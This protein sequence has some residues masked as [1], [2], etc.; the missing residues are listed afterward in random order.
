MP[1]LVSLLID[2]S[3]ERQMGIILWLGMFVIVLC[4]LLVFTVNRVGDVLNSEAA[5]VLAPSVAT[6][7]NVA[8]TA[9]LL[10]EK[11]T[12]EP[13]S[14]L[15][16]EQLR[17][18]A[19][20][21]DGLNEFVYAPGGVAQ[22]SVNLDFPP[23]SLGQPMYSV[24]GEQFYLRVS[25]DFLGLAGRSAAIS[26]V[27]DFGIVIPPSPVVLSTAPLLKQEVF[28]NLQ[29]GPMH[30]MGVEGLHAKYHSAIPVNGPRYSD[31]SVYH[32]RCDD[33]GLLCV[34]SA[35]SLISVL[36]VAWP[37]VALGLTVAALVAL[38]MSTQLHRLIRHY[39]SFESRFVRSFKSR[40]I[41]CT[42][43]PILSIETGQIFGCEV[44]VRWR[45]VDGST[46]FPDQFLPIVARRGLSRELTRMVVQRAFEELSAKVPPH[47]R[48]QVNINI[49][50]ADLDAAWLRHTLAVFETFEDRF[51]VVVE[52]VESTEIE[53]EHAA[54]E[55]EKLR[56]YGIRTQLDD[57]GTGYSNIQNLASLPLDGVK[58]DRSFAMAQD[59]ALMHRM[60]FSTIEMIHSAG[61]RLTVEGVESEARLRQLAATGH[62]QYAQGYHIARPVQIDRFVQILGER[63]AASRPR[64]VA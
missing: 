48:L 25:L 30:S 29:T 45:D 38:G 57:F 27:G 32:L 43:Q 15:F 8:S 33:D 53:I 35:A 24:N 50:P 10:A 17:E 37:S 61:H 58:L 13:C 23:H 6:R 56:R 54:Q 39:W 26:M 60:M 42:Y 34:V 62:V 64:L 2:K 52:I 59:E 12:A 9:K 49:E 1:K 36:Q 47:V 16:H 55:I 14:P 40:S 41:I 31:A 11:V 51:R 20:Q 4:G 3:H 5:L 7:A 44:L 18:V 63:A 22:C 19:F 28:L 21:P 46:I